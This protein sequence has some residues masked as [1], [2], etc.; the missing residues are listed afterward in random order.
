VEGARRRLLERFGLGRQP[1]RG[2]EDGFYDLDGC[3]DL[4]AEGG[5]SDLDGFTD[6]GAEGGCAPS[7]S[8]EV[9]LR[10]VRSR[11]RACVA[12]S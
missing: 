4:G 3:T 1:G 8:P 9:A 12:S 5:F 7:P 11:S 10:I 6:L 2:F